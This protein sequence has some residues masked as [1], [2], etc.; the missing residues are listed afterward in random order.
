M[1]SKMHVRGIISFVLFSFLFFFNVTNFSFIKLETEKVFAQAVCDPNLGQD[2]NPTGSGGINYRPGDPCPGQPGKYYILGGNGACNYAYDP[3]QS[4]DIPKTSP[5]SLLNGYPCVV[6]SDCD[7]PQKGVCQAPRCAVQQYGPALCDFNYQVSFYGTLTCGGAGSGSGGGSGG[8]STGCSTSADCS[9]PGFAGPYVATCNLGGTCSY[10]ATVCSVYSDCASNVCLNPGSSNASCLPV[11]GNNNGPLPPNPPSITGPSVGYTNTSYTFNVQGSDPNS[12]KIRYGIDWDLQ[13]GIPTTFLPDVNS[14][15][16]SGTALP[17]TQSWNV[18]GT[19][20]FQAQ[21]RNTPT[22]LDSLWTYHTITIT[23]PSSPQ[24]PSNP[25]ITGPTRGQ[26]NASYTFNFV[27]TDPAGQQ[28][29]YGV[30]W[31]MNG[32]ADVWVPAGLGYVNSGTSQSATNSW[33]SNGNQPFQVIAQNTAGLHSGWTQ[34]S[35]VLSSSNPPP[36]CSS[37]SPQVSVTTQSSGIFNVRAYGVSPNVTQVYF[38]TWGAPGGQDD[39]VWYPGVNEGGGT[40]RADIDMGNHKNGAPEYGQFF[41]HAYLYT[42]SSSDVWCGATSYQRDPVGTTPPTCTS[43]SVQTTSTNQTSGGL[44]V[45][46]YGVS[47]YVTSVYFP[48]WGAPGGQDD[49]VWYPGTNLGAG[50]WI[51]TIDLGNHKSNANGGPEFGLFTTHVYMNSPSFPNTF[52]GGQTFTRTISNSTYN[53]NIT[54]TPSGGSVTS[55]DGNISCGST[56][57]A[58]YTNNTSLTLNA[59]PNSGFVFVRWGGDCSGTSLTCSLSVNGVK[60]ISA[61][62]KNKPLIYQEF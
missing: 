54:P 20:T 35:I 23:P 57:S 33:G 1:K 45:Y 55:T 6:D 52:C 2:C 47:P 43:T 25:T 22:G 53:V 42:P 51:A 27:S 39:L 62:F 10:A 46:A 26:P 38:P 3:N 5:N 48:T 18:P 60:N 34:Y 32:T 14:Y 44:N 8:G 49:V 16:N 29:R 24:A 28:L 31:D 40:W 21:S 7:W 17:V 19:Y 12:L 36:T 37:V 58:R 59:I 9:N 56:C 50:T 4:A 30:D 15:V 13:D 11:S 61:T 41:T